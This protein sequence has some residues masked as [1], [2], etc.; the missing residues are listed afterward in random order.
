MNFA[1]ELKPCID[2]NGVAVNG[3]LTVGPFL[4]DGHDTLPKILQA[5]ARE[6]KDRVAHREK[7]LGIWRS[8][9]WRDYYEKARLIGLGL[10]A[11]GLVRGD[12]ISILSEAHKEW[13]YTDLGAQAM[14][15]IVSGVYT[16]DS[17]SQLTY[18]VEDSGSRFLFLENDE[19]LDKFFSARAQMPAVDKVIVYDPEGLH[20]LKDDQVLFLDDLYALGAERLAADSGAFDR[21]IAAGSGSDGAILVY[22]SGTTGRPKGALLSQQNLIAAAS[23]M[24]QVTE[25]HPDDDQFCFLPLCHVLERLFSVVAPLAARATVNFVES[26]ETVFSDIQEIS[27]HTIIFV[28]RVWEKLYSRVR[29]MSDDAPRLQQALLARA[30]RL[31][32]DRQDMAERGRSFGV[33]KGLEYRLLDWLVLANLRRMLGLDRIRR[34]GSGA[35]PISASLLKWFH[36][37]GVKV[38]EGY[39]M[40]ES[41][42]VISICGAGRSR[43]GSVGPAVPGCR[44]RIAEDG[45]IQTLSA[46]NF[47]GYW[48]RPEATAETFTQDGWLRTGDTGRIDEDGFLWISGRLKD[49]IITAG[50]KNISP[51]EIENALK[52]SPYIADALVIGDRRKYLTCL[53]MID[54][55]NVERFAQDKRIPFSDFR[56][57]CNAREVVELIRHEVGEVNGQFARVEQ[58]KDFRMI[59]ILMTA[60]DEELTPTMKLKRGVMEKKHRDMIEQMYRPA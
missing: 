36:A 5:R 35:A 16:T 32:L 25:I 49:I 11:L 23:S 44:M 50:G 27:P 33:L 30:V 52:F 4:I 12:R 39:G 47:V 24:L 53:I 48:G 15:A 28:P 34:A 59:D 37:I 21:A 60:E 19:Q 7:I 6:L 1:S 51:A 8:A 46:T 31:G 26:P 10:Q 56:S 57:L 55:E 43:I 14:G 54:Q 18:L 9:S 41:G 38:Y 58:I 20:G 17:A 13:L 29:M 45:E 2:V 42:G 3:D 40:T 22:T